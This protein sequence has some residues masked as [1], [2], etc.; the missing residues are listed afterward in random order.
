MAGNSREQ[1]EQAIASISAQR[2]VLG[3]A[4]VEATLAALRKQLSELEDSPTEEQRKLVNLLFADLVGFTA[5]S[6]NMDPED[7]RS[8]QQAYFSAVT[9][10]VREQGGWIEKYIGDAILAVFGLPLAA[11]NDPDRA[12]RA[13][14]GMQAALVKLNA[15]LEEDHSIHLPAPLQ[16]RIG[17]HTGA[18]VASIKGPGDFVITGE[19]VNLASRLQNAAPVGG[20][21]V[22]QDTYRHLRGAFD[23]QLLDP[24]KF[25][26]KNEPMQVYRLQAAKPRSFRTRK[27]GVEGVETH[28]VGREYELRTLQN[29]FFS[30][31]AE[32]E[33][34][35][36]TIVG[37]PG[38][39][40]SRL[41]YEFENWIDLR[42]E[43]V[44][45]FHGR[46]RQET[47]QL[48]FG[49]L[50][51]LFAFH[52]GVQED[53]PLPEVWQK[54]EQGFGETA[55]HGLAERPDQ[56][57]RAHFIGTLLGY[58]FHSSPA[59]QEVLGDARQ[60]HERAI[61]YLTEF[62]QAAAVQRPQVILLE[63]LHWA[64]DSS[65]DFILRLALALRDRPALLI[66]T[67]RPAL[68]E[69]RP[70]WMEGHD[71]HH[72]LDLQPLSKQDSRKLVEDVLQKV[73]D[74]PAELRDLIVANADGNPF[75]VE[76]LI[77]MLIEEGTIVKG[78]PSWQ[79]FPER[80]AEV[81]VP[82][83]LSGVLLARLDSLPGEERLLLQ[84][85]SVA[86]RVFWDKL[87]M[88]LHQGEAAGPDTAA[89]EK[90]LMALREKEMV[91]RR[92]NSTFAG[93]LEHI[94]KHT[95][96]QEVT[97]ETVLKR[98]RKTYHFR[99]AE[100]LK[101]QSSG[102]AAELTGLI[103][104]HL[105]KA[106][107]LA[108]AASLFARAG[109]EAAAIYSNQEAIQFY[110]RALA[111]TLPENLQNQTALLLKREKL[112]S[113]VGGRNLQQEDLT[114]L[115]NLINFGGDQAWEAEKLKAAPE[116]QLEWGWFHLADG[117]SRKAIEES[118]KA[119]YLAEAVGDLEIALQATTCIANALY[120]LGDFKQARAI[121]EQ[122][123]RRASQ[124]G[125]LFA[126]NRLN[127]ILGLITIEQKDW[128]VAEGYLHESLEIARKMGDRRGEARSLGNLAMLAGISGHL[129]QAQ[130]EYL[131]ALK[132]TR[133]LGER[134]G[135]ANMLDNLGWLS[136]MWG[137]F[138]AAAAYCQQ[139]LQ[140]ALEIGDRRQEM[141][142]HVN[143]SAYLGRQG[144][145]ASAQENA[146]KG[147]KLAVETNATPWVAW[148]L[149][150][151]GHALSGLEQL[152]EARQ[153][154]QEAASL[155][156]SLGQPALAA[157]PQAGLARLA[158][159][160]GDVKA[161]G[162]AIQPI[163]SHLEQGNTLDG[164]DEP[165]RVLL[166]CAQVLQAAGDGR[167]R[168]WLEDACQKLQALAEA[169]PDEA[170]RR[171]LLEVAWNREITRLAEM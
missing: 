130:Q 94:F 150:Y 110:S 136:G 81:H 57:Y 90:S 29:T 39:G 71:F 67:A 106:S 75:Y 61:L 15:H 79:V 142:S 145:Y 163:L 87:V 164:I 104:S 32:D 128:E 157:E 68:Y 59:I 63:D 120:H 62:F 102:G 22:S 100:W 124:A 58:D 162:E 36:L 125:N 96:L 151:L 109:D 56:A 160:E 8:I 156:L 78:E 133:K 119:H 93:T 99:A 24:I 38:L 44:R 42:P 3:E 43:K 2:A 9:E 89:I 107:E 80:L 149:T 167:W 159:S 37:E 18:V 95:V 132:L 135:E 33:R 64:D 85:A 165:L 74:L 17:I 144:K 103:A 154:Y 138:E 83:T 169:A 134:A 26:G 49:L 16:M 66:G 129:S 55:P 82:Q 122:G 166:T 1:L 52:W 148:A 77:K 28:M 76:E 4:V 5:L 19:A 153:T 14:L 23:L 25:K 21:L 45:L 70:S 51:D 147:L 86:G 69:R 13:A 10:P 27:R 30:A 108:E 139:S 11:E 171:K 137:D 126:Q 72:R 118:E 91:Y 84:Q 12:A 101:K 97:Y 47:Q 7:L 117:D 34:S 113:L 92:E 41:L 123:L 111:L 140:N 146:E 168:S 155:R 105:E 112:F 54:F 143:L 127:N 98:L 158:L 65:L 170:T 131:E 161:A 60:I 116:I 50:R 35:M 115:N 48:P 141:A 20:I 73:A 40:K 152:R 121:G 31:V 6:E 88:Y 53:D 114:R 46:A